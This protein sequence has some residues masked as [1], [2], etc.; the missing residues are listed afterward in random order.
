MIEWFRS[1]QRREQYILV[2]GVAFVA[3][4]IAYALVWE[5]LADGA[6]NYRSDIERQRSLLAEYARVQATRPADVQVRRPVASSQ[7]LTLVVANTLGAKGLSNAYKSSAD[8]GNDSL[9]VALEDASFDTVIEWLAELE[10]KHG[11]EVQS[12]SFSERRE[13]GRID[14]SLV[15]SRAP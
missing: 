14:S 8:A 15:L 3:F 6:S 12:G 1:L 9:R 4:A 11:I 2:A 5:P 10:S 13:S 7:S